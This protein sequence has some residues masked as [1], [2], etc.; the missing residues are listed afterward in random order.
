MNLS[1][2]STHLVQSSFVSANTFDERNGER[3]DLIRLMGL[4]DDCEWNSKAEWLQVAD[5]FIKGDDFGKEVHFQL[6]NVA[7]TQARS[8]NIYI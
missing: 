4:V 2:S 5:F 3:I 6:Q 1:S 7:A 8:E